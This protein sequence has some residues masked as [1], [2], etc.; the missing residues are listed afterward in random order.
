MIQFTSSN[1]GPG[2]SAAHPTAAAARS[3]A[4]SGLSRL[5]DR[6]RAVVLLSGSVRRPPLVEATGRAVVDLPVTDEST[7]LH[8][9]VRAVGELAEAMGR[10]SLPLRMLVGGKVPPPRRLPRHPRVVLTVEGDSGDYRGTAGLL[11]DKTVAYDDADTVLVVS[12]G[13]LLLEPLSVLAG[14]LAGQ[15]GEANLLSHRDGLPVGAMLFTAASLR[16]V[17]RVGYQDFKEQALPKIAEA[18]AVR[19][20]ELDEH[21]AAPVRTLSGYI[22]A[23]RIWH[24]VRAGQPEHGPFDEDWRST[25]SVVESG[26]AAGE[27]VM[28]HDAVVLS[29]AVLEPG[30]VLVRSVA[31]DGARLGRGKRA[32][33][34]LVSGRGRPGKGGP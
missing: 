24:R 11:R 20:V 29:G 3:R 19:V 17:P 14:A 33:D 15:G 13:Q 4:G 18:Y 9:W 34:A 16:G 32:T 30:A 23:L 25:F 28:V 21:V 31:C 27:G 1:G 5:S 7:I 6:L 10:A 8:E 22:E 2:K 26:A 12:G